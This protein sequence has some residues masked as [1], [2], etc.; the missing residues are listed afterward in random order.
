MIRV[1]VISDEALVRS[2]LR[3]ILQ[4]EPGMEVPVVCDGLGAVEA[5]ERHRPDVVLLDLQLFA[6]DGP[7]GPAVLKAIRSLDHPPAVATLTT[8]AERRQINA[9]LGAGAAAYLVKDITTT[10]LVH[11]VCL[12]ASGGFILSRTAAAVMHDDSPWTTPAAP[13]APAASRVTRPVAPRLTGREQEVLALLAAGMSNTEISRMLMLSTNTVKDHV[14]ASYAKLGVSNRV[15]A[16]VMA[17][18]AGLAAAMA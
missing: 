16:A 17:S 7:D 11:A 14:K 12:L 1:I 2:G 10:E 5:V 3:E 9:V 18:A 8:R 6:A 15:Q 4:G 13:P